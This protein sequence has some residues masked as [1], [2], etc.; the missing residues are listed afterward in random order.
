MSK[1]AMGLAHTVLN[2]GDWQGENLVWSYLQTQ[3]TPGVKVL[4]IIWYICKDTQI[5]LTL[6]PDNCLTLCRHFELE[7]LSRSAYL[8]TRNIPCKCGRD[9]WHHVL[10]KQ[11]AEIQEEATQPQSI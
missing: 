5:I 4:E 2:L 7:I 10:R 9:F 6:I 11:G 3:K 8:G 1:M